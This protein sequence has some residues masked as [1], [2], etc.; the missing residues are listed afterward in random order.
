[1]IKYMF[2]V[3]DTKA[4]NYSNPFTAI[5]QQ[6]AIRDFTQAVNESSSQLNKFPDDFKLIEVGEFDDE[7]CTFDIH[8]E[9]INLGFARNFLDSERE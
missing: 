8:K 9:P 3:Y 7:N 4:R 2:S 1:M 5:N 6:V